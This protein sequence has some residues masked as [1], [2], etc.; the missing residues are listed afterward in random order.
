M[1]AGQGTTFRV[2][3]RSPAA[4]G[5]RASVRRGGNAGG[6]RGVEVGARLYDPE[7]GMFLARDPV[8]TNP[9]SA[10]SWNP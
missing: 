9:V 6:H 3:K 8:F 5:C 4:N 1:A 2:R 7:M 10:Q